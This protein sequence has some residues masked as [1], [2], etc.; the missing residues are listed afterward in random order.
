MY[1]IIKIKLKILLYIYYYYSYYYYYYYI[2][3]Y[4]KKFSNPGNDGSGG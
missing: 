4:L 3:N 1:C 2:I